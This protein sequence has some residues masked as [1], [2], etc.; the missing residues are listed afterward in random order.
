MPTSTVPPF[1]SLGSTTN[2][3]N[4][5][6]QQRPNH[7]RS[8]SFKAATNNNEVMSL[9][10]SSSGMSSPLDENASN[11]IASTL[12]SLG[13]NEEDVDNNN[14]TSND[15]YENN[16]Q[17]EY[18]GPLL[19]RN[20]SYTV[21]SRNNNSNRD[22]M[23]FSPFAIAASTKRPRAISLGMA[24]SP[25]PPP[26]ANQQQQSGFLP[27]DSPT[28]HCNTNNLT[29]GGG[30]SNNLSL[31]YQ[32]RNMFTRMDSHEEEDHSNELMVISN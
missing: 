9:Y 29:D 1:L 10:H 31:L 24:D 15:N 20:R 11:S 25:L 5:V 26:T 28:F 13:L 4:S 27:F 2:L 23:S 8:D 7:N 18:F 21:S 12:A 3:Y 16:E 6:A 32:S 17:K 22:M 30:N 19:T 14:N